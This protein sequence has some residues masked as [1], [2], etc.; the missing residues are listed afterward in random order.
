MSKKIVLYGTPFCGM[1]PPVRSVLD[2]AD[3]DYQYV[4]ISRN[5]EARRRVREINEGLES[6]PTLE[7]PDGSTLT[8]PALRELEEKLTALGLQVRPQVWS[9]QLA[10]L[11]E[12]QALR[13][14]AVSLAIVGL[15]GRKFWLLILGLAILVVSLVASWRRRGTL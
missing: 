4:D 3:A 6:V 15:L 8:E 2:R 11:L 13:I 7:F 14:V 9:D 5:V 10:L 1:V 12:S